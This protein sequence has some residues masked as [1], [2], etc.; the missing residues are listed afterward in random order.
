MHRSAASATVLMRASMGEIG[1]QS[2]RGRTRSIGSVRNA[3]WN[4]P[5]RR[6]IAYA[7]LNDPYSLGSNRRARST[8]RT[9]FAVA[10]R[11]WSRIAQPPRDTQRRILSEVCPLVRPE[12]SDD[13]AL[14]FTG[15]LIRGTTLES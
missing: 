12:V 7:T 11:P 1:F 3:V 9:K 4:V 6:R 5:A 10:N 8:L 15:A 2:D 14:A 13:I